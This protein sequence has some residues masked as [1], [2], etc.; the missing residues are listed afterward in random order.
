MLFNIYYGCLHGAVRV[1]VFFLLRRQSIL[2]PL[3]PGFLAPLPC[4]MGSVGLFRAA[5]PPALIRPLNLCIYAIFYHFLTI[6]KGVKYAVVPPSGGGGDRLTTRPWRVADR[7]KRWKVAR[8]PSHPSL[9][10]R[11]V[12][13]DPIDCSW[14]DDQH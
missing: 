2:P 7:K 6:T 9:S 1:E 4:I 8:P 14:E 11:L 13:R 5:S 12:P 3:S 10:N